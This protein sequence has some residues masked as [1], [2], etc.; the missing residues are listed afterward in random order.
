MSVI[1]ALE[2]LSQEDHQFK[3]SLGYIARPCLN[4]LHHHPL[5]PPPKKK[6]KKEGCDIE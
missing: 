6:G 4:S 1:P 3:G 5:L 2:R